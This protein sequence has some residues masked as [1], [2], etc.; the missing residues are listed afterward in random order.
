MSE[1]NNFKKAETLAS[2]LKDVDLPEVVKQQ[3]V[4]GVVLGIPGESIVRGMVGTLDVLETLKAEAAN[5]EP[6]IPSDYTE[7]E[8]AL[9]EMLTENTGASILD[10]G[11]IHGRHW[12]RNRKVKDFRKL[13]E[14]NVTV[15][16]D[17]EIDIR[18][19]V[20]HFLRAYLDLDETAKQLNHEFNEF[21]KRPEYYKKSWLQVMEEFVESLEDRRFKFGWTFNT[22]N[23]EYN[24]LS[25]VLQGTVFFSGDD[26][27]EAYVALQIHN[28]CDV[29]GGYTRPRI[30]RIV[31]LDYFIM[32]M[33]EASASCGCTS[34]YLSGGCI[35]G[36]DGMETKSFPDYWK[37]KPLHENPKNWEYYLM[38]EK[39]GEKVEFY[40]ALDF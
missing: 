18:V 38:C 31:D 32:A 3:A 26:E 37:P 27:K 13:P 2:Y 33:D 40:A 14:I 36:Q 35:Y 11:S 9:A 21:E 29:R 15:W 34:V 24:L 20:F 30:F 22:Y 23:D 19:N 4:V 39:C 1:I 10:S 8:R 28:G 12:Q 5:P 25:Q 6:G 7:L 17:G 16:N